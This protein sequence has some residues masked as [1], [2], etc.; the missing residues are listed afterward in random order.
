MPRRKGALAPAG[1]RQLQARVWRRDGWRCVSCRR[2][3][4]LQ[5]HHV[6]PRSQGGPDTMDNAVALCHDCHAQQDGGGWQRYR[7]RFLAW[8]Q[9][10]GGDEDAGEDGCE[11]RASAGGP[12]PERE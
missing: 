5:L 7:P 1:Y 3:K 8:I 11:S 10:Q 4:P 9:A 6:T 2:R 12:A